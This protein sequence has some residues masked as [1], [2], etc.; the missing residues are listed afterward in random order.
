M[1]ARGRH[2]RNRPSALSRTS[3]RVTAGGVGFAIPLVGAQL[4]HAAPADTWHKAAACETRG[5][6]DVNTGNGRYGGLQFSQSTW[7]AYGGT[8]YA[9]RADLATK[10]Q[11]IAVAEKV[12]AEQ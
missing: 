9:P 6:W 7:E 5:D 8:A 3:L 11:Q 12:L 1:H 2:G 10:S 4:V